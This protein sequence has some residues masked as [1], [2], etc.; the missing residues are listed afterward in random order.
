MGK[1]QFS[2]AVCHV[3]A[4]A[5]CSECCKRCPKC[6]KENSDTE[7]LLQ[8]EWLATATEFTDLAETAAAAAAVAE[9]PERDLF[10]CDRGPLVNAFRKHSKRCTG[11][12]PCSA[13]A[14]ARSG[15]PASCSTR[16]D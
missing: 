8:S 10:W 1:F 2:C 11:P 15:T 12:S 14:A 7:L 4:I 16:T 5:L 3:Q 13:P 6:G 9:E